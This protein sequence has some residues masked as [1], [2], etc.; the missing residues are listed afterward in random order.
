MKRS[1]R[2]ASAPVRRELLLVG[3]GHSHV[4]VVGRFGKEPVPGLRVT[5]LSRDVHT[6]YSGMLPG[7]VAGHYAREDCH[8]DLA[9]LCAANGVR[10]VHGTLSAVD[11]ISRIVAIEGRGGLAW[12]LLSLNTGS[13]P[14]LG[15][16]NGA[17]H[18]GVAVKP[19]DGFL[20]RWQA[21]E[22][23]IANGRG[24]RRV[25]VVGGGAAAV[26]IVLAIAW[27]L[28]QRQIAGDQPRLSLAFAGERILDG[29]NPR[30]RSAME[31]QLARSGVELRSGARVIAA[32]SDR[33]DLA[34]GSQ[35]PCELTIWAIHAGAPAWAGASGLAC[36]EAGFVHVDGFLRS[37]SHKDIFAAGDIAS[38]PGG[39]PKSGVYAVRE[40]IILAENL[41]RA[42]AGQALRPY[43]PQRRFLSLLSTGGRH[44][45][46]SRGALFAQGGWVWAW[47]DRIDRR[48]MTMHRAPALS[49]DA[50]SAEDMRCG[51]CAAKVDA[52]TLSG[53]LG[54]VGCAGD[55]SLLHGIASAEDAAVI[56][57]P[58]GHVLVQSVDYFRAFIDDPWLVGRIGA[59][60]A[61]GD[62]HAMGATPHSA[63]AVATVAHAA[64]GVV[65]ETLAQLMK[66]ALSALDEESVVLAGGH[67]SEGAEL[68]FGLSVN[69][70]AD[71]ERLLLKSGLREGDLLV[72]T[73]PLGTG[74]LFAANM[75]A[76]TDGDW[77]RCALAS[78]QQGH[79]AAMQTLRRHGVNACTDVTGFGLLGHLLEM[80]RASRVEVALYPDALPALPGARECLEAGYRSSLHGSNAAALAS[81][82][83]RESVPDWMQALIVDP[84]TAGGLL[85]A[86]PASAGE[87]CL[88]DLRSAGYPAVVVARVGANS[89][90]GRI[91]ISRQPIP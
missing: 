66:G 4:S 67:S 16:I 31:A 77:L 18:C 14:A 81:L 22:A 20:R 26:E 6:P 90:D 82:D 11:P 89:A 25:V 3:G 7:L 75:A 13:T 33:L 69:G 88:A 39:V 21:A 43:R 8:I 19:I 68:G 71:R 1:T 54:D 34:D 72:L 37:V 80:V 9:R 78:M 58:P 10:F 30:V 56:A 42:V 40:G 60:H 32:H 12:D 63:L 44:A 87:R 55:A 2:S 27:R 24:P 84:Q 29:H 91:R 35:L 28:S 57:P 15:T 79:A 5:L 41:K 62:L 73:K 74:V 36:D 48:F 49:P 46:A 83:G 64:P 51:G 50:V 53:V 59:I 45:V 61:L 70:F 17:T 76:A 47:K 65:R 86:I 38:L 23:D 52:Q 85:A